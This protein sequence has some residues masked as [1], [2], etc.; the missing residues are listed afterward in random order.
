MEALR[1][2]LFAP[3]AASV[4]VCFGCAHAMLE[5][6]KVRYAAKDDNGKPLLSHPY[7]PWNAPNDPKYKEICDKAYRAFKM[8]ENVKEWTFLMLPLVWVFAVYGSDLPYATESIM[9]GIILGSTGLYMLGNYWYIQGY[10]SAPENRIKGFTLR[11]RV[12]EFWMLGSFVSIVWA[13]L[14]R[15]GVI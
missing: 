4:L 10:I 11:R 8:F 9:D 1:H 12:S 2:S 15:F 7:A 6:V 3:A 14:V 5:M 13:G